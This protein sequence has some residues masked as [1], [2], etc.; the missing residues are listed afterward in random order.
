MS[1]LLKNLEPTGTRWGGATVDYPQGTFINGSGQGNRD[2][3]YAKAEWANEI[4]G[5]LGAILTN[6][7]QTPNGQVE[8]AR[9]SQVFNALKQIIKNDVYAYSGDPAAEASGTVNAI[10]ATFTKPVALEGGQTVKVRA[11]GS[12]TSTVPTFNPNGLGAKP[13]VKG[14]NDP[15]AVGDIAGSGYWITL[16]YDATLQKW[17]LQNPATGV[18]LVLPNASTT[19]RGIIQLATAAEMTAETDTLKAVTVKVIADYLAAK[20]K[21]GAGVPAG[22]MA[23]YAGKTIP[24]GWL[25]CNGAAV[26]RTT[27]ANLFAEIGTIYGAGDGSTTF[28][29]PNLDARY[30]QYTT[31]TSKVGTKLEAGL[32]NITGSII[33]VSHG[34]HVE[35]STSGA[36]SHKTTGNQ[37]NSTGKG[38]TNNV[39]MYASRSSSIFGKS[40]T[41]QTPSIVQLAIIKT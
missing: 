38:S 40:S 24:E 36:F 3:S 27:Y 1:I 2:G 31:S 13:I 4:F 33:D 35:L 20:L 5:V 18:T 25:I 15:L 11:I 21:E 30:V 39:S 37:G 22:T 34:T 26:S 16:I 19:Q 32:P 17:V 23:A 7:G 6:G 9:N 29:L 41:V 12:N 8:T 28:N 10:T 14:D